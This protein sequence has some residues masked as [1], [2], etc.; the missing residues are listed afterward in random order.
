MNN[1]SLCKKPMIWIFYVTLNAFQ[2]C[3]MQVILR[4]TQSQYS[5]LSLSSFL[6]FFFLFLLF[7]FS[8]HPRP[9]ASH[10]LSIDYRSIIISQWT[11]TQLSTILSFHHF[12]S[13]SLSLSH[14]FFS[15]LITSPLTCHHQSNDTYLT[16]SHNYR[17]SSSLNSKNKVKTFNFLIFRYWVL[18]MGFT[19]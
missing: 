6:S 11:T 19:Y 18:F 7:I 14:F 8:L 17:I 9:I 1:L 15:F 10:H 3:T 2:S 4:A 12:L 5:S 16:F 13:L